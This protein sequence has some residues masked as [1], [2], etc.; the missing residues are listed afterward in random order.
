MNI[1]LEGTHVKELFGEYEIRCGAPDGDPSDL[2]SGTW[3][4]WGWD[5]DYGKGHHTG[6][7]HL[8]PGT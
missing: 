3:R 2:F 5:G 7:T 4:F 8:L 6:V 1:D